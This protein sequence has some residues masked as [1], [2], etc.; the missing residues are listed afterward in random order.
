MTTTKNGRLVRLEERL[1][2]P[3]PTCRGWPAMVCPSDER[4]P[5]AYPSRC[6]T[7]DKERPVIIGVDCDRI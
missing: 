4:T 7:C 1:R 3:C 5:P 6:P 2:L